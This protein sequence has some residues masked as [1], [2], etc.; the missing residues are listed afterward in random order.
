MV[1]SPV[2]LP[3]V[4]VTTTLLLLIVG[5][6]A[7][8]QQNPLSVIVA[9]PAEVTFPKTVALVVK[10]AKT[11]SVVTI[12]KVPFVMKVTLPEVLPIVLLP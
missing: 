4:P 2:K 6:A 12:A 8:F 1:A 3:V 5:F 11:V 10:T 7:V 9:L